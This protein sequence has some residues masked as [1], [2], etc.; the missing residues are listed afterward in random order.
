MHEAVYP[1]Q[2]IKKWASKMEYLQDRNLW[3][4]YRELQSAVPIATDLYNLQRDNLDRIADDFIDLASRDP[5]GAQ[6]PYTVWDKSSRR[7]VPMWEHPDFAVLL[8]EAESRIGNAADAAY[9]VIGEPSLRK[10]LDLTAS[11]LTKGFYDEIM[12]AHVTCRSAICFQFLPVELDKDGKK[13]WQGYLGVENRERTNDLQKEADQIRNALKTR[14]RIT[15]DPYVS[16]VDL[17]WMTGRLARKIVSAHNIP[18]ERLLADQAHRIA[19]FQPA[20]S[21]QHDLNVRAMQDFVSQDLIPTLDETQ[22]YVVVHELGHEEREEDNKVGVF[23]SPLRESYA[24]HRGLA[25][26]A[27]AWSIRTDPNPFTARVRGALGFALSDLGENIINGDWSENALFDDEYKSGSA[28]FLLEGIRRGGFRFSDGQLIGI[29]P[30][31]MLRNCNLFARQER[32][33][34]DHGEIMLAETHFIQALKY[35]MPLRRETQPNR[36]D[37]DQLISA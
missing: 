7:F 11:G 17:E 5:K 12:L 33:I 19:I 16:V 1:S 35:R 14:R 34:L 37:E 20:I 23:Q 30:E 27:L 31:K 6:N 9:Y 4:V 36:N 10:Y 13:G 21:E 28:L 8:H 24:T 29:D 25:D 3:H 32:Y 18:N 26:S 2:P 15:R 22:A